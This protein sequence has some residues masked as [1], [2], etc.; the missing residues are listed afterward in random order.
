M[1]KSRI[2]HLADFVEDDRIRDFTFGYIYDD[3]GVSRGDSGSSDR[4]TRRRRR[5][6]FTFLNINFNK[7]IR[8]STHS[9]FIG[10]GFEIRARN[11]VNVPHVILPI[12]PL[13]EFESANLAVVE[14]FAVVIRQM[15]AKILLVSK[16]TVTFGALERS[17]LVVH[18]F[19][20]SL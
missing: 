10:N 9:F 18:H 13:S 14:Q 15:P 5:F 8:R 7:C 3:S 1:N 16:S 17:I 12:F 20:V 4:F 19:D 11:R 2:I 6:R